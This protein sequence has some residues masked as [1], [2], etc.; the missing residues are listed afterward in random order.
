M[1]SYDPAR[2]YEICCPYCMFEHEDSHKWKP[3][4]KG[5]FHEFKCEECDRKFYLKR[6]VTIEYLTVPDCGLIGLEC[7]FKAQTFW[8]DRCGAEKP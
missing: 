4:S 2:W 8:C 7:D 1:P 3:R 6:E 5:I